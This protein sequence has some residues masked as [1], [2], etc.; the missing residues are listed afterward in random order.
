VPQGAE[1]K[2]NDKRLGFTPL[3]NRTIRPGTGKLSLLLPN[4][5]TFSVPRDFNAGERL[6]LFIEMEKN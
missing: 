1:V 5:R 6:T 2:W 4:Y 3:R